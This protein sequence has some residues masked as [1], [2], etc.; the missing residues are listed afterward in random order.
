[1]K[2]HQVV[3]N[4]CDECKEIIQATSECIICSKDVC[5]KHKKRLSIGVLENPDSPCLER[6]EFDV[7]LECF[8]EGCSA[9]IGTFLKA[10]LES[11]SQMPQA[12][13]I[14]NL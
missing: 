7:C 5:D 2:D 13:K 8:N 9:E 11:I 6:G 12:L 10:C 3:I 1:M 14:E 4:T